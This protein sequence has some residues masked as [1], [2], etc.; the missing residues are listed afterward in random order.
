MVASKASLS[1]NEDA[2]YEVERILAQDIADGQIV[3][4]V[5]WLGYPDD[6]CTWEPS[7][8]FSNPQTLAD[9]Q[10]QLAL[11]DALDEEQVAALQDRMNAY[12]RAKEEDEKEK[13]RP[14]MILRN[15]GFPGQQGRIS[16]R[17][18]DRGN[19][20]RGS[21]PIPTPSTAKRPRLSEVAIETPGHVQVNGKQYLSDKSEA[22]E[23]APMKPARSTERGGTGESN[24]VDAPMRAK[25]FSGANAAGSSR[26]TQ[27]TVG[28]R[29]KNL[30]HWNSFT[31][32]ARRE[33]PPDMS[34][35]QLVT[36]EDW[37]ASE[38]NPHPSKAREGS[39]RHVGGDSWHFVPETEKDPTPHDDFHTI[40]P[41]M[42]KTTSYIQTS[43][44]SVGGKESNIGPCF[45]APGMARRT[46]DPSPSSISK[47]IITA[48]NGRSWNVGDVAINLR[49]GDRVV[50]DV[51]I[52][53]L[54]GWLR[55]KLISLKDP[56]TRTINIHFRERNAMKS[57]TFSTFS[58]NLDKNPVALGAI[59]SYEDTL[60]ATDGLA[61]HLE[62]HNLGAIW[63]YP[64]FSRFKNVLILIMYSCR[65]PGW[66]H[67]GQRDVTMFT[68]RLHVAVRNT[69][70]EYGRDIFPPV[71]SSHSTPRHVG[72]HAQSS[73]EIP[74][75][76]T[77]TPIGLI[78]TPK[79][80]IPPNRLTSHE[81]PDRT[82]STSGIS[83]KIS[84]SS[85]F[86]EF[87]TIT[88]KKERKPR[89]YIAF[90]ESH[91]FEA[92]A[93][94]NRLERHV[95]G[96]YI[97]KS[98]EKEAWDAWVADTDKREGVILFHEDNP[99]YCD[100]KGFYK[101][102]WMPSFAFY[103]LS[104]P[105]FDH[106]H[107]IQIQRLFP[108]GNT[109][110]IT[111]NSMIHSSKEALFAMQWF[112]QLSIGKVQSWKLCLV[113]NAAEWISRQIMRSNED[114]QKRY[115]GMLEVMH[116]LRVQSMKARINVL[117]S[118][119]PDRI[120]RCELP[121]EECDFILSPPSFENK[122]P[123]LASDDDEAVEARDS[124]LL[125]YYCGWAAS[126]VSQ[127]RKFM[128]LD[129]K[130]TNKTQKHSYHI[131]FREPNAFVREEK[132]KISIAST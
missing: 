92:E 99:V 73:V 1:G 128:V 13:S 36:D 15:I 112:E 61:E 35:I 14:P 30:G 55:T 124:A 83:H 46:S 69:I 93:I 40:R 74:L 108:R 67:L 75:P 126:N 105:P 62:R 28:Q 39:P 68:P 25:R 31:K 129:D 27:D 87:L 16:E 70:P 10:C 6:Q 47:S 65:A 5:K 19:P 71:D 58:H 89:F 113:P 50:G 17:S 66:C 24:S 54:P 121:N 95:H 22:R 98:S 64:E 119:D 76:T 115:L 120:V 91:P 9:W 51:K 100:L 12:A 2:E 104:F 86:E 26:S 79:S 44:L 38:K 21:S 127:Y 53:H 122:D 130:Y 42:P 41:T 85:H 20:P 56:L 116:R 90:A 34:Q 131:W 111:E 80:P 81:S 11:G 63:V 77:P 82:P 45:N 132:S 88:G 103:N 33:P 8:S 123:A 72:G 48:R 125:E 114:I 102:L 106:D 109:L 32:F 107:S 43:A 49:F 4:L 94:Q 117:Y 23:S 84:L 37:A 97:Y 29:F 59:E 18:L 110:L 60:Q 7:E 52:L 78:D 96:R 57:H 118:G 101:C 3:Y